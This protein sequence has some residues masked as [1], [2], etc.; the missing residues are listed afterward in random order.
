MIFYKNA[1]SPQGG[2]VKITT[3]FAKKWNA[4]NEYQACILKYKPSKLV[5]V[6]RLKRKLRVARM[7]CY[8]YHSNN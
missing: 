2:W 4:Q 1:N 7:D 8:F 3:I 5:L 6:T